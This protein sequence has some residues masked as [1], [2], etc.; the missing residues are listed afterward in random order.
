MTRKKAARPDAEESVHTH[1]KDLERRHK[2]LG[3]AV[4]KAGGWR[5]VLFMPDGTMDE[6]IDLE[7]W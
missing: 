6:G 3:E 7:I 2:I 5:S 1:L 4:N